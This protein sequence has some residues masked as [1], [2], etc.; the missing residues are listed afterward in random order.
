MATLGRTLAKTRTQLFQQQFVNGGINTM[1][2]DK[3]GCLAY[4]GRTTDDSA[5]ELFI[6]GKGGAIAE[7]GTTYYNRMYIPESTIVYARYTALQYNATDDAFGFDTGYIVV[8]NLNGTL[9][10]VDV[11]NGDADAG[12]DVFVRVAIPE[13]GAAANDG[14]TLSE[15]NGASTLAWTVN[16][17][18]DYLVLTVTGIA[19]KTIFWKVYLEVYSLN[20]TECRTNFFFGDTAAQNSGD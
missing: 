19:A 16:D 4:Y 3:P 1:T 13:S 5:T 11:L 18:D 12:D 17:T 8:S 20:E 15:F 6:G 10:G 7:D 9:A 14:L 2:G